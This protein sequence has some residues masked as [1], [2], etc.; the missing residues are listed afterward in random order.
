MYNF[1]VSTGM[2]SPHLK[3]SGVGASENVVNQVSGY[4]E[5]FAVTIVIKSYPDRSFTYSLG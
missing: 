2:V 1:T 5:S 4:I 3:F